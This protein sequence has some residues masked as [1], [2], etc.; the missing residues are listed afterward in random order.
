MVADTLTAPQPKQA[1]GRGTRWRR[2][3]IVTAIG[4]VL[5]ILFYYPRGSWRVVGDNERLEVLAT[6]QETLCEGGRGCVRFLSVTL[7]TRMTSIRDTG[8]MWRESRLLFPYAE[9]L[10]VQIGD[11]VIQLEHIRYPLSRLVPVRMSVYSYWRHV[12]GT[13]WTPSSRLWR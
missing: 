3:V 6:D 8:T 11:S 12:K 1:P 4:G 13:D 7:A 10:A 9:S 2:W 5:Y